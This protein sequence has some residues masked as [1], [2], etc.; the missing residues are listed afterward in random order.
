M[1]S[2]GEVAAAAHFL[3]SDDAQFLSGVAYDVDGGVIGLR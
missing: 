3:C 2:A 1:A